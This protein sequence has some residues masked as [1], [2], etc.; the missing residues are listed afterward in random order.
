[1]LWPFLLESCG[2]SLLGAVLQDEGDLQVYLVACDVAILD[3]DVHVLNPGALNVAQALVGAIEGFP[4]GCLKALR[5]NGAYLVDARY[6]HISISPSRMCDQGA[7]R[8]S[9]ISGQRPLVGADV[10][11]GDDPY[12]PVALDDQDAVQLILVHE[13]TR[14]LYVLV[15]PDSDEFVRC[16][17]LYPNTTTALHR[18]DAPRRA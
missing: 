18:S 14:L 3:H 10:R 17:V 5:G 16:D 12:E 15:R 2:S 6:A 4:Y 11:L 8:P 7:L 1:M 13:L 9:R